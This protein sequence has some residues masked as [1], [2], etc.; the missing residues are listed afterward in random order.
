MLDT[1]K[2]ARGL[3]DAGMVRPQVEQVAERLAEALSTGVDEDV[4]LLRGDISTLKGDITGIKLDVADVKG[5]IRLVK[6][7]LLLIGGGIVALLFRAYVSL[8]PAAG[9]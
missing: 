7:L 5:E 3:E 8:G 1:L 9:G 4:R 6:A 2:L